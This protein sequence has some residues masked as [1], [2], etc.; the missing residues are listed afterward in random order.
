MTQSNE[1]AVIRFSSI[2]DIVLTI[3]VLYQLGKKY[4]QH[5]ITFITKDGFEDLIS[6]LPVVSHVDTIKKNETIQ[7]FKKRINF[8]KFSIIVDLHDNIRSRLLTAGSNA[9]VF[10]YNKERLKRLAILFFKKRIENPIPIWKKYLSAIHSDDIVP[11]FTMV[12]PKYASLL[13][14]KKLPNSPFLVIAPGASWE[15]KEWPL[16]NYQSLAE[17]LHKAQ[18]NIVTIG[19]NKDREVENIILQEC[20][21]LVS[22]LVGE[23]T[24]AESA[25]VISR[26]QAVL[27]VDT[28]MMHIANSYNIPMTVLFGSTVKEFGFYP[29]SN[30]AKVLEVDISCRPCSLTGKRSCPKKHHNCMN[31]ITAQSVFNSIKQ[32]MGLLNE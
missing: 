2:G 22:P 16:S 12:L 17:L 7:S 3:P 24:I 8:N 19:A 13:H 14:E 28:G 20:G 18:I 6:A 31:K 15:S 10:R 23:L 1:I 27:T 11:N 4:P 30:K 25:F 32:N 9:K 26:A 29:Y 21:D 5:K